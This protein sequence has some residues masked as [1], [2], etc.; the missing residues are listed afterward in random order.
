MIGTRIAL[1]VRLGSI[2]VTMKHHNILSLPILV[3][4]V[5]CTATTPAWAGGR[6]NK[7]TSGLGSTTCTT[8]TPWI[9]VLSNELDISD[10]FTTCSPFDG[11]LTTMWDLF[12]VVPADGDDITLEVKDPSEFWGVFDVNASASST[13]TT[14]GD[15][16]G[17]VQFNHCIDSAMGT[18]FVGASNP[19]AAGIVF[20]TDPGALQVLYETNADGARTVLYGS[21]PTTVPE[22][23]TVWLLL[24]VVAISVAAR[25]KRKRRAIATRPLGQ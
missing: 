16:L 14:C 10:D 2:K 7:G 23:G 22:P 6:I 20:Y 17:A 3:G 4:M 15:P 5:F 18:E 19:G 1:G 24:A 25:Y 21:F 13:D 8:G 9:D 12:D 11:T